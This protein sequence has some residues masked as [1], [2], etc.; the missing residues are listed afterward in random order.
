MLNIVRY[1][2]WS[3]MSRWHRELD[4]A[5]SQSSAAAEPV[6]PDGAAWMPSVVDVYD[7]SG[8]YVVRAD[9]PGVAAKDIEVTAE[10]GILTISDDRQAGAPA[11]PAEFESIERL[12]G[13]F[14]RRFTRPEPAQEGGITANY[15]NGVLEVVIPKAPAVQ[16]KRISVT[17]N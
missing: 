12:S 7:E 1:Q 4:Q 14:M 10:G 11:T 9:I 13:T 15:A 3:L 5:L 6:R 2:P 17:V 16:A 8:R